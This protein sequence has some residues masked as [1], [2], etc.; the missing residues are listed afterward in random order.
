M[1]KEF[2]LN[3]II[4]ERKLSKNHILSLSMGSIEIN[5]FCFVIEQTEPKNS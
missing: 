4:S 5:R 3:F 2:T 1:F